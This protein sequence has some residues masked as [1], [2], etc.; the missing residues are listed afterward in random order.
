[1][2]A[3]RPAIGRFDNRQ[4]PLGTPGLAP[5]KL[6]LTSR[7]RAKT[8]GRRPSLYRGGGLHLRLPSPHKRF[9]YVYIRKNASSA[10]KKWM[11]HEMGD[12][13]GFEVDVGVIAARYAV[14]TEWELSQTQRLLVLRDPVARVCSLFRNKL[15]QRVHADDILKNIQALTGTHPDRITFRGFIE[16]YIVPNLRNSFGGLAPIDPHCGTQYSHLWPIQYDVVV[17]LNDLDT[18]AGSLFGDKIAQAFFSRPQN[19]TIQNDF[20]DGMSD[21]PSLELRRLFLESGSMP[22][23]QSLLDRELREQISETYKADAELISAA[24]SKCYD[25]NM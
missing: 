10:F 5:E 23:D 17:M 22:S 25:P 1:M 12:P 8:R 18:V 16:R 21:V 4:H 6:P 24:F 13:R 7:L 3:T 19:A 11:L 20:T 14:S 9:V 15:V 2:R